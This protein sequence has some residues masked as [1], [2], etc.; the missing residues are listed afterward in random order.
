MVLTFTFFLT[1]EEATREG[2]EVSKR[3]GDDKG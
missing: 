3:C 1:V 2:G